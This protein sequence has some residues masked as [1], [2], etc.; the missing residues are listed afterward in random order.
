MTTKSIAAAG[1][2][3]LAALVHLQSAP[4]AG[5]AGGTPNPQFLPDPTGAI[6]N[7]SDNGS[8]ATTGAFFQSLGTNGRSCSTCHVASQAFGLSAAGAQVRC[9]LSSG[10]RDVLFAPVDGA[11][12][13]S[14][15]SKR[16]ASHSLLL[17]SGID[18]HP[19]AISRR[20]RPCTPQFTITVIHDPYGCAISPGSEHRPA[21]RVGLSPPTADHQSVVPECGHVRWAR[22][23]RATDQR[24]RP[25][26]RT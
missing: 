1:V 13:P 16:P 3:A 22:D 17:Q 15:Q 21:G 4:A 19:A 20:R 12:C 5:S 11:N 8:I 2:L 6:E 25:S 24:V 18:P 26:W 23:H 10:G 14:A 9:F 7:Y